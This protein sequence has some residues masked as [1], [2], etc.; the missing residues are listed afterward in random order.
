MHLQSAFSTK[1]IQYYL[2]RLPLWKKNLRLLHWVKNF[3]NSSFL[4]VFKSQIMSYTYTLSYTHTHQFITKI[5]ITSVDALQRKT[6]RNTPAVEQGG[7]ITCCIEREHLLWGTMG[8]LNKRVF[9]RTNIRFGL[10]LGHLG[11]NLRKQRGLF[12][13]GCG[14]KVGVVL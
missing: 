12:S 9:E 10:Q 7:F 4:N 3:Q 13:L 1:K 8:C 5:I 2:S 11:G 6:T 14:Q